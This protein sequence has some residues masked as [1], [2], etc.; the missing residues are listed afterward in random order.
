LPQSI[1]RPAPK[2]SR[3][4][5]RRIPVDDALPRYE[6]AGPD[7]APLIVV[8]GGSS[9]TAHVTATPLDPTPGWWN[10]VVGP[11]RGIDTARYRVLSMDF[12]DGGRAGD[13]R[14]AR[15]VTTHDQADAVARVLDALEVERAHA[16]VGASYGGMVGL[17]FAER[18]PHRVGRLVAIS[19][20]QQAHPM[21]TALRALQRNIVKLG[22]A[23]G[24]VKESLAL[25]RGL[26]MTTY[27][28]A[29]EFG[30]RFA[31]TPVEHTPGD[32]TFDVERYLAHHGERFAARWSAERF[33]ALSLSG[34]LHRVDPA[35]IRVSTVIVAAEGDAIV[36]E[37]QLEQLAASIDAPT[38]FIRLPSTRGHDAFLT[39]PEALGSI[40]EVAI[41]T[42]IVS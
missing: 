16:F 22:L 6:V 36:P 33:I 12:L 7:H 2:A 27:R 20:P 9:A 39:E 4:A 28:S 26:A 35:R 25:A 8:L 17:A 1:L 30:E 40:L 19:A 29:R 13:G 5:R 37:R 41:A 18:Y 42:T 3:R 31:T 24:R 15:T 38:R 32:A 21:S 23:S 10:D 11:N 14:P 34:D